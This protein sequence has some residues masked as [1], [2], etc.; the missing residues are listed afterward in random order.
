M[1]TTFAGGYSFGGIFVSL[2]YEW[3]RDWRLATLYFNVLVAFLFLVFTYILYEDPP[4]ILMKTQDI[5]VIC[6]TLN[7]IAKFN[8]KS[9]NTIT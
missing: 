7:K 1:V 5:P 8:G 4:K 9:P 3:L 6:E 2:I